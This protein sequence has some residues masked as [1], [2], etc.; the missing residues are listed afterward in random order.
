M[1]YVSF[2]TPEG[3]ESVGVLSDSIVI[4]IGA[5]VAGRHAG[6][7]PIRQLVASHGDAL[8]LRADRLLGLPGFPIDK[9]TVLPIVPD[10]SD[11]AARLPRKDPPWLA[12]N[13]AS[14]SPPRSRAWTRT[15]TTSASSSSPTSTPCR[16]S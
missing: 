15:L 12:P 11:S 3:Y 4:D 8:D 16:T 2:R 7:S 14:G 5:T 1:K 6:L 9:V 13:R 10:P